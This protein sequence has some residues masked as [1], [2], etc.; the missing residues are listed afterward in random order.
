MSLVDLHR[1][2]NV[3]P[4]EVHKGNGLMQY[5]KY[6]MRLICW[7]LPLMVT[8]LILTGQFLMYYGYKAVSLKLNI[9]HYQKQLA[10]PINILY[11]RTFYMHEYLCVHFNSIVCNKSIMPEYTTISKLH[12][13]NLNLFLLEKYQTKVQPLTV[14]I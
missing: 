4:A 1:T 13:L 7:Y 2:V 5:H 12:S 10:S 3:V 11:Y 14:Q 6:I 8:C 9:Q